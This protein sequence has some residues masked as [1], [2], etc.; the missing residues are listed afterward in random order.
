VEA[1]SKLSTYTT[2]FDD[3]NEIAI[4]FGYVTLFAAAF[5]A[6]PA[7]AL[8]NN[9]VEGKSDLLKLFKG[10][11]RPHPREASSILDHSHTCN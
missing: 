8:L 10:M 6:A 1:Q 5:P 3:Y 11:Q 2:T 7:A 4:Q 9:L